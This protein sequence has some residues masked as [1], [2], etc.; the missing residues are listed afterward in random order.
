MI[1]A[2]LE[3]KPFGHPLH[4]LLVH[5]PIGLLYL[6]LLL[7]AVTL[8]FEP[9]NTLVRGAFY[10]MLFALIMA[11]VAAVPG[12]VDRADIRDGH[13]A[14]KTANTHMVLNIAVVGL[15]A[16]N[17]ILRYGAL[18]AETAP[19]AP[20]VLSL[21]AVALVSYS[22]YLGGMLVYGDGIA[23]GRHRRHTDTPQETIRP[24]ASSA[25]L[26]PQE[27]G[28]IA[29]AQAG[30]L[31]DGET[32]RAEIGGVVLTIARVEG[33][34]YAFQEFCTHRFGP[35]S[36]GHFE[37]HEVMCPWHNSC[38][39]VRNGKVTRGPAKVDLKTFEV[40]VEE[41]WIRVRVEQES[42]AGE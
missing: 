12:L 24:V 27:K 8:F 40:L 7:D 28:T 5:L 38:F 16:L 6:S 21:I 20:F 14:K 22:G 13:P 32:L 39:D 18:T 10:S 25:A 36:E 9:A 19:I 37:G 15:T 34:L 31:E 26:G 3:G 23:V 17:L 41:G 33:R 4:P 29:V 11:L 30:A 1:K 35:L 2:L 42:G